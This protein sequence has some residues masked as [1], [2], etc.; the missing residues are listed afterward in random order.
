MFP[1]AGNDNTTLGIV[2]ME[3]YDAMPGYKG[4]CALRD[5]KGE[6][7]LRKIA[8]NG[9]N[10]TFKR[11]GREYMR[12]ISANAKKK[13]QENKENAYRT[14]RYWDGTLRRVIPHN[15]SN[16][17]RKQQYVHILLWPEGVE[18]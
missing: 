12:K 11:Y 18:I 5:L 9:G 1:L 13:R 3:L 4:G 17:V 7:Y 2:Q 16:R 14:V 10:K 6:E 8:A 15:R